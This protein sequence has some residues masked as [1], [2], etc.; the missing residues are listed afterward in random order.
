MNHIVC[1]SVEDLAQHGVVCQLPVRS[2]MPPR[3]WSPLRDASS[4]R[5]DVDADADA[6]GERRFVG[7]AM[8]TAQSLASA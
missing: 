6:V 3:V 1:I 7:A 2:E 8:K 5:A 4:S